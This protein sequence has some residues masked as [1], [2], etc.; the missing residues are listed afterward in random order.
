[1]NIYV[2]SSS[3]YEERDSLK[4]RGRQHFMSILIPCSY[5]CTYT[6]ITADFIIRVGSPPLWYVPLT[7]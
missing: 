3:Y 7:T 2:R 5:I 6:Y 1:V 4:T